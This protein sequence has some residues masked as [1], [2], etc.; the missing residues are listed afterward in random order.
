MPVVMVIS[1]FLKSIR[2][3]YFVARKTGDTGNIG[4]IF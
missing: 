1:V 2:Y 3:R 4:D